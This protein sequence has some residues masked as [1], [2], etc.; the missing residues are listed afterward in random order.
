MVSPTN[1]QQAPGHSPPGRGSGLAFGGFGPAGVAFAFRPAGLQGRFRGWAMATVVSGDA[2]LYYEA[3]GQGPALVFAHGRGGNAASWWQ[4]IPFFSQRYRCIAFDQRTFGRSTGGG[5]HFVQHQLSADLVAIL[6]AEGIT[7]AAVVG[8]SMG[9]WTALGAAVTFPDRIAALVLSST[10]GGLIPPE[11]GSGSPGPGIAPLAGRTTAPD[12]PAREPALFH[13]Y[14]Q[15]RTFNTGFDP[16][17]M[18][19]LRDPAAAIP[20]GRLA[21]CRVP[22]LFVIAEHDEIFPPP[23]L[24]RAAA[25]IQGAQVAEIPGAGHSPYWE[26]PHLFNQAVEGFLAR[27]YPG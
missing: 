21:A 26:K 10:H 24:R 7:R 17:A 11:K 14:G 8:Q 18:E 27:H 20:P 16:A 25:A 13:L 2:S 12:Y 6:D 4:Q 9:G 23:L 1:L 19:H 3:V 15:L 22:T 5:A